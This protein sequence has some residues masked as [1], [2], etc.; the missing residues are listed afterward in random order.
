VK[1]VDAVDSKSTV[2]DD[3]SVRVRPSAPINVPKH[4]LKLQKALSLNDEGLFCCSQRFTLIRGKSRQKRVNIFTSFKSLRE[5]Y[6][7][8][9]DANIK[10]LKKPTY[11]SKS[12]P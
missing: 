6:S 2:R 8:L 9:T 7:M 1:L 5:A 10:K 3:V 4:F 12:L 11:S